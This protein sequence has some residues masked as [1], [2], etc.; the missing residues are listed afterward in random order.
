MSIQPL[1]ASPHGLGR[2]LLRVVLFLALFAALL[3][4][5]AGTLAWPGA[6]VFLIIMAVVSVGGMVWLAQYDP[7]LLRERLR[8]PIQAGQQ[9]WDRALMLAF[10][11]LWFGWYVLMG[12]DHRF[13]WSSVPVSSPT[14]NI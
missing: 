6:W 10:I 12:F 13:G 9:A 4:I 14:L 8:P 2:I 3:F 1:D 7:D 5:P 11:P